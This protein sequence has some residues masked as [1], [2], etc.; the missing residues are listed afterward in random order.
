MVRNAQPAPQEKEWLGRFAQAG[1]LP[2]HRGMMNVSPYAR[3]ALWPVD[4]DERR[5]ALR[6]KTLTIALNTV[7][8]AACN[9]RAP[10]F[11]ENFSRPFARAPSLVFGNCAKG[12]GYS[13][14]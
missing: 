13:D 11:D 1:F 8:K 3:S 9:T 5:F 14:A 12:L 10:D 4:D 6:S 7:S 2:C